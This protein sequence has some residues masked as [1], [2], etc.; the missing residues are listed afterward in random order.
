MKRDIFRG[1]LAILLYYGFGWISK[2]LFVMPNENPVTNMANFLPP[3]LGVMWGPS[4]AVGSMV[5]AMIAEYTVWP[6]LLEVLKEKGFAVF[7]FESLRTF[8]NC[9]FWAFLDAYL[10]WRL[11]H[12]LLVEP[13][14][15]LFA[16]R[17]KIILKYFLILFITILTSSLFCAMCADETYTLQYIGSAARHFGSAGGYALVIFNND[18]AMPVFF[19]LI[20]FFLLVSRDYS[21]YC[22]VPVTEVQPRR[23]HAFDI[24]WIFSVCLTIF[25]CHPSM[26]ERTDFRLAGGLL[27]CAYMFRPL[28]P[29]PRELSA[30]EKAALQDESGAVQRIAAVFYGFLFVLFLVLD[31]SGVI[32]GLE[33][34]DTWMQFNFECLMTMNVAIVALLYIVLKYRHSIMTDFAIL[35]VAAVF[36]SALALGGVGVFV[37]DRVTSQNVE[38][39]L[40][41]MTIICRERLKRTFDGVQNAAESFRNLALSE[42]SSYDRLAGDETYRA[43]YL[44]RT[45]ALFRDVA[46]NADGCIS[47]YYR[48]VPSFSGPQGGF[49]WGRASNRWEGASTSFY[50][51][52]PIDLSQYEPTDTET[53]GWY[54]I[55][56]MRHSATWIEPYVDPVLDVYVISYV[57]PL[58]AQQKFIGVVGMDLDFDYLIH[59]IR[60]MSVYGYGHVYLKDRQGRV[61]YHKDYRQGEKFQSNPE[62]HEMETY[63]TNG[64]WMG[65]ATPKRDIYAERNNLLMHLVCAMLTVAI[66][67]SSLSLFFASRGIRPLL[68]LNEAARKIAGGNLEVELPAESKDELGTLVRSIRDMVG[69][70][71]VFVY[72]DMLTGLLNAAAYARKCGELSKRGEDDAPYAVVVFDVNFLKKMNDE[73]GHEAGNELLRCAAGIMA[74]IFAGSLVYR[75]GGDEFATILEG[76]EYE[77]RA[78]LIDAFDLAVASKRFQMHNS[79]FTLS[80]A[81]GLAV[82]RPGADYAEIFQEAD[83]AMY[84][85]KAAV[86]EKL[87][88]NLR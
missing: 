64:I 71:E 22:P 83:D 84:A 70:L 9:A 76:A 38:N 13:D 36:V 50:R 46:L 55:P 65:I 54:Y 44:Q 25:L 80:V 28:S 1:L 56:A 24:L 41:E 69:K 34:I 66:F 77:R 20:A 61:L 7:L 31:L 39:E 67:V 19:G 2:A 47:F 35:E 43:A 87:G 21:F 59:E 73:Y 75:I 8:C 88:E 78:E 37:V 62:F 86:K 4:A 49:S 17:P 5:G 6:E 82:W 85:H 58:Y 63:L 11:W 57:I 81:R 79:E 10:P 42:L 30:R 60:R 16:L 33:N 48:L 3:L 26:L 12:S 18:F 52:R 51:R 15:P 40:S 29:S 68:A 53:V 27:L 23:Q 45:E 74:K 72:R 32:Y 14:E